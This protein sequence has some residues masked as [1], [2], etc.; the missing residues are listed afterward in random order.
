MKTAKKPEYYALTFFFFE[1]KKLWEEPNPLIPEKQEEHKP[2]I[3]QK[4]SQKKRK[5]KK[6]RNKQGIAL[7]CRMGYDQLYRL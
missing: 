5:R 3:A 1:K 6:K 7:V 4:F 2:S